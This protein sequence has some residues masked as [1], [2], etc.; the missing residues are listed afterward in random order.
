[1]RDFVQ[2]RVAW[3]DVQWVAGRDYADAHLT[4]RA[5]DSPRLPRGMAEVCWS[6][7]LHSDEDRFW[8]VH[9]MLEMVQHNPRHWQ[10]VLHPEHVRL[11]AMAHQVRRDMHKMKAFVRFTRVPAPDGV[12]EYVAWFEPK[13]FITQATAGFFQRRFASMRWSILTPVGSIRWDG[14]TL[15]PGPAATQGDA[16]AV[17]AGEELWLTYYESIFNPARI[18]LNAMRKEMPV[19]YWKNLPEAQRIPGLLAEAGRRV[20]QM[21]EAHQQ[22]SRKL[23]GTATASPSSADDLER[24]QGRIRQCEECELARYATQPVAGMGHAGAKYVLIGEQPGDME[25]LQGLPFV[26]P[27]GQMVRAALNQLGIPEDQVY[28]TNAVKHF[29]YEMRG[30]RRI[31]KTPAQ[32]DVENCVHWLGEELSR[33]SPK[34]ILALGRTAERAL[35]GMFPATEEGWFAPGGTPI[36]VVAHPAALLRAGETIGSEGF[37]RWSLQIGRFLDL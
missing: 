1:M 22:D 32:R 35:S 4:E 10:D 36:H 3:D 12:E 7:L 2:Q 26:G 34:V 29:K 5:P 6:A 28:L 9:S 20:H 23:R 16:P 17:D 24:L 8:R 37:L 13:H 11:L 27:A 15:M 21:V 30:K 31:H 18:K 19:H 14:K 25:D 33:L